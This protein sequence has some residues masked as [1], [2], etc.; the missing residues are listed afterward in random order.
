MN[1]THLPLPLLFPA[2]LF[3]PRAQ[4]EVETI[5][6]PSDQVSE[7]NARQELVRVIMKLGKTEAAES[8]LRGLLEIRRNDPVLLADLAD[9]EAA[10]GHVGRS[11]D[12]YKHA[13]TKSCNG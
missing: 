11:R 13:L 12:L 2:V 10:R 7:F 6:P 9:I 3:S 4:T 1:R 5:V 8:E